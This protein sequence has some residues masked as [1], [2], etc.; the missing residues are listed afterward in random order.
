MD[1]RIDPPLDSDE[2]GML[3]GYLNFLRRTLL[4]KCENVSDEDLRQPPSFTSMTLLG[5]VKHLAYVERWWIQHVFLGTQV[6]FPWTDD[7]PDADWRVEPDETTDDVLSLYRQEISATDDIISVHELSEKATNARPGDETKTLRW[8]VV[9][10]I[11][12]TGRHCG[13]ADLMRESI[14]G[15]T[16]E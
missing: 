11:E 12:E 5:M 8:I 16:G 10:L 15:V 4:M 13:H 7:D 9:H 2:K 1:T 14:D 3:L 6:R